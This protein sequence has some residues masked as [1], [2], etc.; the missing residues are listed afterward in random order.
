MKYIHPPSTGFIP[1][2]LRRA[3]PSL[4]PFKINSHLDIFSDDIK[5][6]NLGHQPSKEWLMVRISQGIFPLDLAAS[7]R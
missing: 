1:G 4:D 6:L 2:W 7:L 3:L 5:S